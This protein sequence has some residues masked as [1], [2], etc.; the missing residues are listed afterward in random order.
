MLT[1]AGDGEVAGGLVLEELGVVE[2][3]KERQPLG[4]GSVCPP[5][6]P[7]QRFFLVL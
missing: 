7:P 5:P 6:P 2:A 1:Q 3:E 4:P